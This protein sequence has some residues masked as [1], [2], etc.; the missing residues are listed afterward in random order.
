MRNQNP[1][2]YQL[3]YRAL[4]IRGVRACFDRLAVGIAADGGVSN[5]ERDDLQ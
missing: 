1:V 3:H 2:C 5:V 4:E